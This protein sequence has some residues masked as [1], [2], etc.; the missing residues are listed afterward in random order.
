MKKDFAGAKKLYAELAKLDP[1][2]PLGDIFVERC[3]DYMKNKPPAN[4]DGVT[5]MKSK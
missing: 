2:N 4:W 1:K 5:H 3:K